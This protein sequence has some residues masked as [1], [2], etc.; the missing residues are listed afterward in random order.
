MHASTPRLSIRSPPTST[1]RPSGCTSRNRTN[2]EV[3]RPRSGRPRGPTR[4]AALRGRFSAGEHDKGSP[5]FEAASLCHARPFPAPARVHRS[6]SPAPGHRESGAQ[7]P[8]R[9]SGADS[10]LGRAGSPCRTAHLSVEVVSQHLV[11]ARMPQLGHRL[12]LDL[13]DPLTG[14]AVDLAD[15]VQGLRLAVGEPEPHRDHAGLA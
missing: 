8:K 12:G 10:V 6:T 1:T 2:A 13:A 3:T 7:G 15:L 4:S 14:D 5:L 11:P 9:Y